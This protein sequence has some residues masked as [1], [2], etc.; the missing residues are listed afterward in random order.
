[1]NIES[2]FL[3][4]AQFA[5]INLDCHI[6]A[7]GNLHRCHIEGHKIGTKNG[8][9]ILH[10][11][12]NQAGWAMNYAT[13]SIV[14]WR[15]DGQT[16]KLSKADWTAIE[17]A[18]KHRQKEQGEAHHQAALK[19]RSIWNRAIFADAGNAYCYR[20]KI[21]PHGAKTGDS[22]GL[23]GVLILPLFDASLK[24][25][26]LQFIQADGTKRFL[27]GGQKKGCF[28]WVGKK[29][30]KILIA[31]GFSTAA[32]LH[33]HTGLQVFVA[34]DAGNLTGV[35]QVVRSN[36]RDAE[37]I[38]CGD[39]DESGVGQR[40]ARAAALAVGG[41]YIIPATTGHDWNDSINAGEIIEG[42]RQ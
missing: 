14:K 35:A 36:N 39:N 10:L 19:A 38:I 3:E 11:D 6:V 42:G 12:G 30:S 21:K 20:K 25:V 2:Q 17:T 32:S 18:K 28:W 40:K 27:S 8:A 5:G 34:F 31:E 33:E 41:K 15:S 26:N 23:K 37:I 24:L 4:A 29:S 13:G 7:D 16:G 22:G 1:M 9:Y